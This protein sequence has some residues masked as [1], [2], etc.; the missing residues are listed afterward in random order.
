ME[1]LQAAL[2]ALKQERNV[3]QQQ[4]QQQAQ[5]AAAREATLNAAEQARQ[6]AE[7]ENEALQLEHAALEKVGSSLQ[8]Q[9]AEEAASRQAIVLESDTRLQ[10]AEHLAQ[11]VRQQEQEAAA[12]EERLT[13]Q[14]AASKAAQQAADELHA[15][16]RRQLAGEKAKKAALEAAEVA[17]QAREALQRQVEGLQPAHAALESE[18][19]SLRAQKARLER[20]L[21][22]LQQ[23]F[24][25]NSG[26]AVR[27]LREAHQQLAQQYRERDV[28]RVQLSAL[29]QQPVLATPRIEQQQAELQQLQAQA[30]LRQRLAAEGAAMGHQHQQGNATLSGQV[31]TR[32]SDAT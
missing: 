5:E 31:R 29:T 13:A 28:L 25:E 15:G 32:P 24:Y 1:E 17:G 4:V 14:A 16:L 30:A 22:D 2:A 7:Q 3:L 18:C 27:D 10:R 12:K 19:T 6:A 8:R 21:A 26:A 23:R 20:R 9:L 11:L